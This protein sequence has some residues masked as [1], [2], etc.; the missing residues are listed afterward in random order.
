MIPSLADRFKGRHRK[1]F[2]FTRKLMGIWTTFSEKKTETSI[3]NH[4]N[5]Y[6]VCHKLY[7]YEPIARTNRNADCTM[8]AAE[9]TAVTLLKFNDAFC[10][11]SEP[12]RY[13]RKGKVVWVRG[14]AFHYIREGWKVQ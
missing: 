4:L 9:R 14:V 6:V 8:R 10:L 12:L 5:V 7:G 1:S 11:H 3:T 2:A 13:F